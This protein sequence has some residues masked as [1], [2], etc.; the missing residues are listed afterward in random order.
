VR[1][2]TDGRLDVRAGNGTLGWSA[3]QIDT[4]QSEAAFTD[5][6]A[7]LGVDTNRCGLGVPYNLTRALSFVL[8]KPGRER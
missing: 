1:V 8:V 6:S 3:A 2:T 5:S 4:L 7:E